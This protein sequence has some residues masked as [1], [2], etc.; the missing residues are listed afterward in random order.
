MM[1]D[2]K[3]TSLGETIAEALQG[4]VRAGGIAHGVLVLETEADKIV[5]V[6][7]F[8][9]DDSR[10]RFVSFTDV[11]AVDYPG[12]ERRFD[13]VYHLLSPTLNARVR[14]KVQANETMQVPSIIDVFPGADWFER[15]TY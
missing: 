14:I 8:L 9:R 7:R 11:T 5:D 10:C 12:R 6:V 3:L 4:A 15:E 2:A 1:D 13:V